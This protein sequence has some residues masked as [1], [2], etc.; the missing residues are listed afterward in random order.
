MRL[1]ATANEGSGSGTTASDGSG[2]TASDG[3]GST[4]NEVKVE[5]CISGS[6]SSVCGG[7]Y[8]GLREARVTCR[9]LGFSCT[10]GH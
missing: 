6:W 9:Q 3:S 5:I 7:I 1:V 8:W 10:Y 4:V 2:A